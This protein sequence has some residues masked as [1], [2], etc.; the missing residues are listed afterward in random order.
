VGRVSRL[1]CIV[2]FVHTTRFRRGKLPHWEVENGSYFVTVRLADSLPEDGVN[3]L[4]AIHL[5][6]TRIEAQSEKFAELQRQY[7]RTME[8]YLDAGQGS[9]VLRNSECARLVES[10]LNALQEWG[11]SAPHY[12]VMPNHW[13]AVIAPEPGCEKS[14]REIMKRVKGRTGKGIRRLISG[15]G[16]VW[17]REWFDRWIRATAWERTVGYIRRNPVKAKLVAKWED[18][19]WTR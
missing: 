8:K 6:L 10:E 16:P 13:H 12:S 1:I 17:Q 11:V 3:R 19:A 5:D 2:P 18:H 7:F 14:L 4:Q 15:V 9:C